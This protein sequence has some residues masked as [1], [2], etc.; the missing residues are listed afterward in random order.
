MVSF[1]LGA[2][3]GFWRVGRFGSYSEAA[4]RFPYPITQ[5]AV[6][7]Q[8]KSIETA[9][10]VQLVV[11]QGRGVVLTP[12]GLRLFAFVAPFM[13]ELPTV[14]GSLASDRVAGELI[15]DTSP[16]VV[17]ELVP[18][19][20]RRLRTKYPD[21]Q[22]RLTEHAQPDF[23]RLKLGQTDLILD[24]LPQIG[25]GL[26]QRT[27]A[28]ARGFLVLPKRHPLAARKQAP[29]AKLAGEPMVA[30]PPGTPHREH[31]DA[32]LAAA[33]VV[34]EVA[35]TASSAASILALV[36][37]GV[38]Y[39]LVPSFSERGPRATGVVVRPASG[40]RAG[41]ALS[42]V[43]RAGSAKV[44]LVEAALAAW[45]Q[46]STRARSAKKNAR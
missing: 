4:R 15:V 33:G 26:S 25:P 23:D 14:C 38:G 43:W 20:L 34:P 31:Q 16:L 17:Q 18:G 21:M 5:P 36:G 37:A 6:Y 44:S 45:P 40:K 8:V 2:L 32:E 41:F 3:E 24:Y 22:L 1:S 29:L 35:V 39:S 19:W 9:L 7:Q 10:D 46:V 30:Y 11:R 13:E 12:A 28:T 42:A 27:V